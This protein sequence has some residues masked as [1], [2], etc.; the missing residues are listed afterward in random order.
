M[1]TTTLNAFI[2]AA[3]DAPREAG[4][5]QAN[6][7]LESLFVRLPI[8]A[9]AMG[10]SSASGSVDGADIALTNEE[11]ARQTAADPRTLLAAVMRARARPQNPHFAALGEENIVPE[12]DTNHR[13]YGEPC[14]PNE[15]LLQVTRYGRVYKRKTPALF[16]LRIKHNSPPGM[17]YCRFCEDHRPLEEF[18]T[19]IKR[20][21]CRKHHA[22]RVSNSDL[23]RSHAD[24]TDGTIAWLELSMVRELFGYPAVNFDRGD[25]RS[26]VIHA[27]LPWGIQPRLLPIDPALP[28]RPRN[29][30]IVSLPTFRL[31]LQLYQHTCSRA[32]YIAHIQ[33]CNLLPPNMD[34]GW[35]ERPFHDPHFRR[36]DIDVGPLL[37]AECAGGLG[38]CV[39]RSN[40]EDLIAREPP[41]P[42][43]DDGTPMVA[44]GTAMRGR[45]QIATGARLPSGRSSEGFTRRR[46]PAAKKAAEAAP[47]EPA[48]PA[49]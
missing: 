32:L 31:M 19:H 26:L 17:R 47:A 1:A 34:V 35:P 33:R 3:S 27:G 23:A 22:L 49:Q 11:I 40:L 6:V 12:P 30:A 43:R 13:H 48:V 16:S 38:E 10:P 41:A 44:V 18:Y 29:V 15:R 37:A 25:I 24:A 21:V 20:Y 28:L 7:F 2:A 46:R 45:L 36:A 42:W 8:Q 39:D 9:P 4:A 5:P 14:K